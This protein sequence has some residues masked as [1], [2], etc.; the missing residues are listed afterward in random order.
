MTFIATNN[1]STRPRGHKNYFKGGKKRN[2]HL[3][4]S[5]AT[6][7]AVPKAI[8]QRALPT[9]ARSRNHVNVILVGRRVG[10]RRVQELGWTQVL[11]R[12]VQ[13]V[14]RRRRLETEIRFCQ[15]RALLVLL[16]RVVVF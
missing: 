14:R 16:G 8:A 11:L 9:R 4:P 3:L 2:H 12:F 5:Q 15:R 6:A 1:T 13:R 10:R 7:N